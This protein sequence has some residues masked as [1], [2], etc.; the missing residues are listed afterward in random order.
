[1]GIKVDDSSEDKISIR[2]KERGMTPGILCLIP[3]NCGSLIEST[4]NSSDPR[5]WGF[6]S[7]TYNSPTVRQ[8]HWRI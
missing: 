3:G 8:H 7:G 4:R 2:K 5:D 6:V 1:M